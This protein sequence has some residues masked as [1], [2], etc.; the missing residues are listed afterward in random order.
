MSNINIPCII[1]SG[2]KSSRMG[3]DKSLLPFG[4]FNTLIE[5]QYQKLSQI[6]Q[7]VY[8]STKIDKFDFEA[9]LILDDKDIY[10]P[11]V[12]LKSILKQFKT[13]VFIISVDTPFVKKETILKLIKQSS[14]FDI[15]IAQDKNK[16]HNLC[17]IFEHKLIYDIDTL[18]KQDIH[19]IN[20]L[21]QKNN[22][23]I[24]E[25]ENEKQFLNINT[26]DD[27]QKALKAN[28]D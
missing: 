26:K 24:I 12:A 23:N 17:G 28:F 8:I 4:E 9:K 22:A 15:T 7:D 11:M 21:I 25:F 10:S 14:N 6:F 5:Y 27:Y 13:K 2:G 16:T 19:K 3:E 1:L 18:L 20:Y